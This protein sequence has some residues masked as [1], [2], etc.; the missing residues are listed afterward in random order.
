MVLI[1][2]KTKVWGYYFLYLFLLG[3][4]LFPL[5]SQSPAPPAIP[6]VDMSIVLDSVDS[7]VHHKLELFNSSFRSNLQNY[8]AGKIEE[9]RFN[10]T[11]VLRILLLLC[12]TFEQAKGKWVHLLQRYSLKGAMNLQIMERG[13]QLRYSEMFNKLLARWTCG[14]CL[15]EILVL[16][17]NIAHFLGSAVGLAELLTSLMS[18]HV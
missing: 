14:V 5:S 6:G 13:W 1:T 2:T 4:R 18:I 9:V 11:V 16:L 8:V 10:V 12:R 15:L 17:Y 7:I 3:G